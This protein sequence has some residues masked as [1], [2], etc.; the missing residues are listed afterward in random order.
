MLFASISAS[1]KITVTRAAVAYVLSYIPYI[2]AHSDTPYATHTIH[3]NSRC[4]VHSVRVLLQQLDFISAL[5][6]CVAISYGSV[7]ECVCATHT[8]LMDSCS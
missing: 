3:I 1:V 7:N 2:K 4:N 8:S 6:V 5:S